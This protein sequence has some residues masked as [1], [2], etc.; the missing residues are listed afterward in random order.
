MS[1]QLI[2]ILIAILGLTIALLTISENFD[3]K[4]V[5]III[6]FL[7]FIPSI[8]EPNIGFVII[9]VSILF[10]PDLILG[11]AATREITV[12]IEDVFLL[13]VILAW[14]ARAVFTKQIYPV[15]QTR[16]TRPFFL[17]IFACIL[18]TIF[19][20]IVSEIDLVLSFFS[21]LK[22]FEYFMFFL[23][24][25]NYMK[26]L[27]QAK[28]FILVFL[29]TALFVSLYANSYINKMHE[30]GY[31]FFRTAPPV[32]TRGG[33]QAGTLG[34]Y[35][36]FLIAISTGLLIYLKN[37]ILKVSLAGLA[38]LMFKAFAYTLSRGSYLA[39]LP[40]LIAL[41]FLSRKYL[42]VYV[43]I[44]IS[45][46]Y[47]AT[48]PAMIRNRITETVTLKESE[49][50]PP[51][52]EFEE[53]PKARLESWKYVLSTRFPESPIFGHGVSKFFIDGQFFLTLCES[54]LI[55]LMLFI[56]V[57][58]SL[59]KEGWRVLLLDIV[60]ENQFAIG[61]TV[62]FLAGFAGLLIQALSTNTFIIIRIMEPFWF[63][64][65]I[66]LSLPKLL[67]QKKKAAENTPA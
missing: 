19:A 38:A 11:M 37:P 57:I 18:S 17:Y 60:R 61:L 41:I 66:V 42:L 28:I 10:S 39:F 21:I 33:G 46:L 50:G 59:F 43:L 53:S 62:G 35:L 64:A 24:V 30:A 5:G 27:G 48:M 6:F 52:V 22:Y 54:G 45:L 9:I 67:E 49:E 51:A 25:K 4:I 3:I 7:I 1:R 36:L 47:A 31:T 15:F 63:I 16:L 20:S 44:A 55:G 32:E 65:A 29:L 40:M 12:R 34:G 14:F 13:I 2:Y 58:V 23:I 26:T 8:I 56:W